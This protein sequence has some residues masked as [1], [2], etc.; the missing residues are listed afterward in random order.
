MNH[1]KNNGKDL[2]NENII[3]KFEVEYKDLIQLDELLKNFINN[4]NKEKKAIKKTKRG[5]GIRR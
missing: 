2:L 5:R 4:S 3:K 1:Q